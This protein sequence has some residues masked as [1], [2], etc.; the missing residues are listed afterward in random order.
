MDQDEMD[1]LIDDAN[2]EAVDKL[3]TRRILPGERY[4]LV[5]QFRV[6]KSSQRPLR[7]TP[8]LRHRLQY[9]I[10]LWFETQA[11]VQGAKISWDNTERTTDDDDQS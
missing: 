1:K 2:D 11:K 6:S 9:I 4:T 8:D 5:S 3:D 10:A 7:L